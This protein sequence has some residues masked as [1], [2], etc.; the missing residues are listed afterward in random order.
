M[1]PSP[2]PAGIP[3]PPAVAAPHLDLALRIETDAGDPLPA[4][5]APLLARCGSLAGDAA[6]ER[7][8]TLLSQ[9]LGALRQELPETIRAGSYSLGLLL[10]DDATIAALNRQWRHRSGPTDVLAFAALDG[11]EEEPGATALLPPSA[12]SGPPSAGSGPPHSGSGPASGPA[13]SDD[14][15]LGDIVISLETAARQAGGRADALEH[16]LLFLASHGLL[17]LLGWDHPDDAS[18]SAMLARQE[19]LIAG[20]PAA[21]GHDQA[22][23]SG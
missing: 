17:H 20:L 11:F 15:E 19:R 8:T 4:R 5:L 23:S 14:L 16:E 3:L 6:D 1:P 9:W 18:L 12:G 10:T 7:W 21:S 2:A 13:A 22:A